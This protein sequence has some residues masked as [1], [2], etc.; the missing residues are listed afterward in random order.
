MS[1]LSRLLLIDTHCWSWAG[2][3]IIIVYR[4]A[5]SLLMMRWRRA[6]LDLVRRR[7]FV[8]RLLRLLSWRLTSVVG[9]VGRNRDRIGLDRVRVGWFARAG[10]G[11]RRF[12]DRM[13]GRLEFLAAFVGLFD[14]FSRV[15]Q[16]Y[17]PEQYGSGT[18]RGQVVMVMMMMMLIGVMWDWVAWLGEMRTAMAVVVVPMGR[19]CLFG[20]LLIDDRGGRRGTSVFRYLLLVILTGVFTFLVK[21]LRFKW[22]I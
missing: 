18:E 12:Q 3:Y 15:L 20:R 8:D 21:D 19:A 9:W 10:R 22:F 14:D 1:L 11:C 13:V 7:R 5:N 6:R 17:R 4:E 2:S 16:R